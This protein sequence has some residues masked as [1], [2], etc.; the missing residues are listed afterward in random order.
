MIKAIFTN[1]KN[2]HRYLEEWLEYHIRLG[3]NKFILYETCV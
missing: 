1:I 2:E 3:I